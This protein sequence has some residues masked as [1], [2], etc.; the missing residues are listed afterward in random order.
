MQFVLIARI[1]LR[2]IQFLLIYGILFIQHDR[3]EESPVY[4]VLKTLRL[5]MSR[6]L[7]KRTKLRNVIQLS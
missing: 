6:Q 2:I 7:L 3:R 4:V 5:P 1:C